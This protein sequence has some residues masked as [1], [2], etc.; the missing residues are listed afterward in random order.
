MVSKKEK[1]EIFSFLDLTS[2]KDADNTLSIKLLCDNGKNTLGSVA[3]VCAQ[4]KFVFEAKQNLAKT[5]IK[6]ATVVNFPSGDG[7]LEDVCELIDK[8]LIAG[9]DEIDLVFPYKDYL[10]NKKLS[11]VNFVSSCIDFINNRAVVKVILE[12]GAFSDFSVL[13]QASLDVIYCGANFLKTSTGKILNGAT[14]DAATVMLQ[15][16]KKSNAPT[17]FKAAGGIRTYADAFSYLSIAKKIMGN[18][19][20]NINNFRLGTSGLN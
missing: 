4:P 13:K 15:A 3:A 6:V 9:S 14:L 16:I 19:W 10:N 7:C 12:T 18:N 8:C 2:L 20:P 17:G 5:S 1:K 11:A